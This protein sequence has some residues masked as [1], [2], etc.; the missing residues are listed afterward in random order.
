[1]D[2]ASRT[3]A[4]PSGQPVSASGGPLRGD[5]AVRVGDR[6]IAT[7]PLR[8]SGAITLAGRRYSA[9]STGLMVDSG[10]ELVVIGADNVGL[11]VA[12][13]AVPGVPR[14]SDIGKPIH[15]NF[16]GAVRADA[17]ASEERQQRFLSG[18][19]RSIGRRAAAIGLGCGL[20]ALALCWIWPSVSWPTESKHVALLIAGTLG[21]FAAVGPW[22]ALLLDD[23]F[24]ETDLSLRGLT[25]PTTLLMLLGVAAGGA[26][27]IPRLGV[28]S[29]VGLAAILAVVLGSP[30]PAIMIFAVA[31]NEAG[32][33]GSGDTGPDAPPLGS[34]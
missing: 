18:R 16:A 8:P 26:W 17:A 25:L 21:G 10:T 9:R 27:G 3:E 33:E 31:S 6:A 1:M 28:L 22:L 29:G 14:A 15:V 24:G 13:A 34:A 7:G 4:D 20:F 30:L 2:G 23:R 12:P 19:R 11:I 32:P 5:A